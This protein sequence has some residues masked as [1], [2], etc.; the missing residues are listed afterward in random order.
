MIDIEEKYAIVLT[1]AD[2]EY[3][4]D[5]LES[6]AETDQKMDKILLKFDESFALDQDG[7]FIPHP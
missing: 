5:H 2:I 4:L 7:N 3:L 6:I 1:Q